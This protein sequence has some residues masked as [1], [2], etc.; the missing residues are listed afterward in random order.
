M[1]LADDGGLV[2]CRLQ[3]FRESHL[4]AVEAILP[5]QGHYYNPDFVTKNGKHQEQ[6]YVTDIVTDKSLEWIGENR[7]KTVSSTS[8]SFLRKP[9]M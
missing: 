5:G 8:D 9:L 3:Q 2:A 6:G 4:I 7:S 1:P